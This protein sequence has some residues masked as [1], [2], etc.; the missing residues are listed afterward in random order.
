MW[1]SDE[2]RAQQWLSFVSARKKFEASLV[3][4]S[5]VP[6]LEKLIQFNS[7]GVARAADISR[8]SQRASIRQEAAASLLSF[9]ETFSRMMRVFSPRFPRHRGHCGSSKSRHRPGR[10]RVVDINYAHTRTT[11][12]VHVHI[13]VSRRTRSDSLARA[14]SQPRT[15]ASTYYQI[16][17]NAY[18]FTSP[19]NMRLASAAVASS[20]SDAFSALSPSPHHPYPSRACLRHF[21]LNLWTKIVRA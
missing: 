11:P 17:R 16:L 1:K 19:L 14:R 5:L 6:R 8:G 15:Y 18:N 4:L 12:L 3:S 13:G 2:C 9:R 7:N 10:S 20:A 21:L